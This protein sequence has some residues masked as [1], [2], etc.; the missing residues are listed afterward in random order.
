MVDISIIH[1]VV[2]LKNCIWNELTPITKVI[3][4]DISPYVYIYVYV[5]MYI[6]VK[7]YVYIYI[8]VYLYITVKGHRCGVK[9]CFLFYNCVGLY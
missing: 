5:Y 3:Y 8:F 4:H 2:T 1:A 7:M 9:S 6:Y